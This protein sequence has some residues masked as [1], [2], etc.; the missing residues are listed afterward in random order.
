M[1]AC[2][3]SI[4]SLRDTWKK[5]WE[6]FYQ[7]AMLLLCCPRMVLEKGQHLLL[8][9]HPKNIKL[10]LL[11]KHQWNTRWAFARKHDIFTRENNMLFA[12]VKISLLLLL[13]N[14][15]RLSQ[16]KM[17]WHFIGV[18]IINRTLHG[19][20][21][22]RN[23]SSR[24]ETLVKYFSTLEE[25]FRISKGPCNIIY[26]MRSENCVVTRWTRDPWVLRQV[27]LRVGD[28]LNTK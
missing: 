18:Y 12:R 1:A 15:S 20:L 19:R 21:E 8:Q 22:I 27:Q 2:L 23:F 17:V 7:K 11:Y 24:V 4:Q 9:L 3:R 28:F 25:K 14:K 16:D 26:I 13:H 6:T 5:H 10:I